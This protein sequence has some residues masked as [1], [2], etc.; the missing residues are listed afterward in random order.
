M[1]I[2]EELFLLTEE[3]YRRFQKKLLPDH[4]ELI[5]VRL[6]ALRKI[7][8]R[9][10]KEDYLLF[11]TQGPEDYFEEKMLKGMVIGYLNPEKAGLDSVLESINIFIPKIDNWSVCD[12]FCSGLKYAK[13]YPEQFWTFILSKLTASDAF[14]LRFGV[15]M[16]LFYYIDKAHIH[17]A[18]S[19]HAFVASCTAD[20]VFHFAFCLIDKTC[21]IIAHCKASLIRI[22]SSYIPPGQMIKTIAGLFLRKA[23][24]LYG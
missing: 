9:I 4:C 23:L 3:D 18:L 5:G 12:S 19:L 22:V 10:A 1:T 8:K 16:L 7:A 6:P 21:F 17:H 11:L 14:T 20:T 13:V 24:V 15:V 2:R